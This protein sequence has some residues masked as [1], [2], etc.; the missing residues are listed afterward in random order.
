MNSTN[1]NKMSTALLAYRLFT[2]MSIYE[3][4]KF[5]LTVFRLFFSILSPCL[6]AGSQT[7]SEQ[8]QDRGKFLLSVLYL[9]S[10]DNRWSQERPSRISWLCFKGKGN[11]R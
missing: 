6:P 3:P 11:R 10:R 4:S 5:L 7:A 9:S 8:Q 1:Y 2:K